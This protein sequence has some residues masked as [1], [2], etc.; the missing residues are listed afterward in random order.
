MTASECPRNRWGL[1]VTMVVGSNNDGARGGGD[2]DAE[3]AGVRPHSQAACEAYRPS[4]PHGR[5]P[6]EKGY[7]C[8]AEMKDTRN[9]TQ[10]AP[11]QR[12]HRDVTE[13]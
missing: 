9:L 1:H 8:G 11:V 3:P 13:R 2:H 12:T 10:G 5:T 7:F 4:G 6:R